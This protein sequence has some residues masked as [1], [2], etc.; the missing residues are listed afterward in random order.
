VE[1][2]SHEAR[3]LQRAQKIVGE[4]EPVRVED[5]LVPAG[6]HARDDRN[7]VGVRQGI[8]AGDRDA[9]ERPMA[10]EDIEFLFD[11]REGFVPL[12]L[13]RPIAALAVEIA[14]LGRLEP[15][16]GVVG[17]APGK[18]VQGTM[19]RVVHRDGSMGRGALGRAAPREGRCQP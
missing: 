3:A 4:R 12:V 19:I 18:A 6:G 15:G 14:G 7:D 8:A 16:D 13:I 2:E 17:E 10:R 1:G 5:R 11:L 9:V